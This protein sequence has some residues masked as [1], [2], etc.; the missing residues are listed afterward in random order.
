M[1]KYPGQVDQMYDSLKYLN[2]IA[3]AATT[4]LE[5]FPRYFLHIYFCDAN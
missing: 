3:M 5:I 2:I 4:C 1:C